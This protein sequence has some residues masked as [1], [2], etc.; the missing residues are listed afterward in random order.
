[1]KIT[2]QQML[3]IMDETGALN[4]LDIN[5]QDFLDGHSR[6]DTYVKVIERAYTLG[7]ERAQAFV[8]AAAEHVTTDGTDSWNDM[9]DAW[10]QLPFQI[11]RE[12]LT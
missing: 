2:E 11:Q 5:E 3:K 10:D 12:L 6:A 8:K 1:M 9:V 7:C 4:H